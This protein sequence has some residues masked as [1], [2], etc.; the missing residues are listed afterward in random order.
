MKRISILLLLI[1]ILVNSCSIKKREYRKGFYFSSISKNKKHTTEEIVKTKPAKIVKIATAKNEDQNSANVPQTV[2]L[3]SVHTQIYLPAS[4]KPIK[5]FITK[6]SGCG[7]V[8]TLK[9]GTEVV[10]KVLE[11]NETQIKYKRCDNLDGPLIIIHKNDVY[12]IKYRNGYV[13]HFERILTPSNSENPYSG[14]KEV[15]PLA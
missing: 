15:H 3:T 4:L 7:D 9:K 5:P 8:L 6:D 11:I 13:E 12:S 1:V 10:V 2:E 14:K